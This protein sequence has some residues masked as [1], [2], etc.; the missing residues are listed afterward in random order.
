M[1]TGQVETAHIEDEMKRTRARIDCKLDALNHVFDA[2]VATVRRR[3]PLTVIALV[4][5]STAAVVWMRRRRR[6]GLPRYSGIP[7]NTRVEGAY[8]R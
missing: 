5:A 1:D 7:R 6:Q 2:R 4:A 8:L 3:G